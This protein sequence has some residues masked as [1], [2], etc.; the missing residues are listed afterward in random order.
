MRIR[1]RIVLTRVPRARRA[2]YPT[3]AD[4]SPARG[5]VEC[6]T[7]VTITGGGFSMDEAAVAVLVG[8][9]PCAVAYATLE[10]VQCVTGDLDAADEHGD[11]SAHYALDDDDAA[12]ASAPDVAC[13]RPRRAAAAR[14]RAAP[15]RSRARSNPR[16][17]RAG[18]FAAS[19][20]RRRRAPPRQPAPSSR[21]CG[22][23]R[24][25]GRRRAAVANTSRGAWR[26]VAA[27]SE[28][29]RRAR[30][31]SAARAVAEGCS[32]SAAASWIVRAAAAARG[33][34]RRATRGPRGPGSAPA[35]LG[36]PVPR[37]PKT[38]RQRRVR[39]RGARAAV[40]RRR[41]EV[42]EPRD[43]RAGRRA[44]AAGDVLVNVSM[45]AAG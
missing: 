32:G 20:V 40:R 23:S 3:I 29:G 39:G 8:G 34:R 12:R 1:T 22:G 10:E 11:P 14:A 19:R 44:R 21:R 30:A 25:G 6:G 27:A 5:S 35:R 31:R 41:R 33:E 38:R 45:A 26:A 24:R 28:R 43:E 9:V 36:F 18:A 16:A 37:S 4:V 2:Y 7:R 17:A 13:E 42:R 15:A